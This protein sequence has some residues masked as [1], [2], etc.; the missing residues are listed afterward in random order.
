MADGI[1]R[2]TVFS[3]PIAAAEIKE[4]PVTFNSNIE[5]RKDE[6]RE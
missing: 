6:Q 3:M 2:F 5:R 4:S 1:L